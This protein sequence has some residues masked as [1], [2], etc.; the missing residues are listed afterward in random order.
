MV[1][2][3]TLHN[4]T[5]EDLGKI[6]AVIDLFALLGISEE[7]L[8]NLPEVLANWGT[9]KKNLNLLVKD[10]ADLK[11]Q[12][13]TLIANGGKGSKE[14]ENPENLQQSV[15]FGSATERVLFRGGNDL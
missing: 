14:T 15:G 2:I 3:R 13:A 7:D 1:D 4:L 10:V 12:V 9:V 8:A 5:S 11:T 6:Q